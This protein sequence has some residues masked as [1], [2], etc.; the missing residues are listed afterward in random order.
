MLGNGAPHRG[1]RNNFLSALGY[2]AFRRSRRRSWRWRRRHLDRCGSLGLLAKKLFGGAEQFAGA[3]LFP[4]RKRFGR[5]RGANGLARFQKIFNI[6]FANA[7]IFARALNRFQFSITNVEFGNHARD[8]GRKAIARAAVR[9]CFRCLGGRYGGR[10]WSWR[11]T[12]R[13]TS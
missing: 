6:F 1:M 11:G 5:R 8:D 10:R 12:W 3:R 9:F 7:S 13:R 2:A 4:R